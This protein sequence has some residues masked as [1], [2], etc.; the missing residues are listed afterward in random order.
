MI[1]YQEFIICKCYF[2]VENK[3]GKLWTH[4][5]N[6]IPSSKNCQIGQSNVWILVKISFVVGPALNLAIVK[7]QEV[8]RF[9][10]AILQRLVCHFSAVKCPI[11]QA[12]TSQFLCRNNQPVKKWNLQIL[13]SLNCWLYRR[14]P[15]AS[16]WLKVWPG[17]NVKNTF[18][19]K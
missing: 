11:S 8:G 10:V 5:T 2:F 19:V 16:S 12:E 1:V 7:T 14:W 9:H 18:Y 4:W 6:N 3:F 17:A 13:W 15:H